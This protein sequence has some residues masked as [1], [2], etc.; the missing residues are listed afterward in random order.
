MTR[1]QQL[2]QL[3]KASQGH[4]KRQRAH[5]LLLSHR[6]YTIPNLADFFE[7]NRN[8]VSRWMDR[9]QEWLVNTQQPLT[10]QDQARSG[11]LSS[12]VLVQKKRSRVSK[13]RYSPH[14]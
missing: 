10:L 3:Y 14:S 9:W 1:Q 12:L 8:T 11:R 2:T 5:A 6:N 4:R 7:V 13:N